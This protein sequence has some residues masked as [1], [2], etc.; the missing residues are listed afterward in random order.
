MQVMVSVMNHGALRVEQSC[1]M[2]QAVSRWPLTA[3]AQ[4]P[5]RVGPC[6]I[7]SG[8]SDSGTGY[9]PSSSVP[10]V[11]IIPPW[12]SIPTYNLGDKQQT[13]W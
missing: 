3:E 12:L 6:G 2:A 1:T 8:Q 13:R 11:N 9:S 5:A 4:V 7:C 10:P